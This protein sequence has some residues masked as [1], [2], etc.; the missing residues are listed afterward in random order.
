MRMEQVVT[1][2]P[3]AADALATLIS[4]LRN[5]WDK[6]GILTALRT[7]HTMRTTDGWRIALAAINAARDPNNRTP[8]IIGMPGKH[9]VGTEGRRP[10]DHT[11]PKC[12]LWPESHYDGEC[13][14]RGGRRR[15][16]IAMARK[17]AA[18]ARTRTQ[19]AKP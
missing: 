19:E 12:G 2:T 3:R 9:W 14:Q 13:P 1:L 10:P 4:E 18:E 5:D 15:E 6:L 16:F 8:V 7:A 11:C 17:V